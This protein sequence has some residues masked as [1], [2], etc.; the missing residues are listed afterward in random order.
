MNHVEIVY[1]LPQRERVSLRVFDLAGREIAAPFDG[2]GVA[3][4]NT[5]RWDGRT[6]SGSRAPAGVYLYALRHGS[7]TITRRFV[8][9]D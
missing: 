6:R 8:L 1:S 9:L 4:L 3:G 7:T 5:A 2:E